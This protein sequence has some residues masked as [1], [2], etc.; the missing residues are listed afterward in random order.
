MCADD[1][2]DL[3]KKHDKVEQE[4]EEIMKMSIDK[5]KGKDLIMAT[6]SLFKDEKQKMND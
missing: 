1:L 5:N 6:Q 3:R 2:N 4:K